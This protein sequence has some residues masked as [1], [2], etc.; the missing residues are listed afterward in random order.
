MTA[1]SYRDAQTLISN[2]TYGLPS[3]MEGEGPELPVALR[4]IESTC[5]SGTLRSHS[6]LEMR[7]RDGR[8]VSQRGSI[9]T[10]IGTTGGEW[11]WREVAGSPNGDLDRAMADVLLEAAME[12]NR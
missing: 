4:V 11:A 1:L 7:V 6:G 8:V 10:A 5:A 12:M 9:A 3:R 2:T